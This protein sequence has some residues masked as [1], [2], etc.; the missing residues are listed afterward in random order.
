MKATYDG[1]AV[2]IFGDDHQ[3][4][5][6]YHDKRGVDQLARAVRAAT[7][8]RTCPNGINPDVWA[9]LV[10]SEELRAQTTEAI[11]QQRKAA[12]DQRRRMWRA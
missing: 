6:R 4:L 2:L 8:G 11:A 9:A 5:A 3:L 1:A 12:A 10:D 7:A